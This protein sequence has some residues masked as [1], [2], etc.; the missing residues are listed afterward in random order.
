M[1]KD[2]RVDIPFYL[3]REGNSIKVGDYIVYGNNLGRCAQTAL[4]RVTRIVEKPK[5]AW[6]RTSEKVKSIQ[7]VSVQDKWG[8]AYPKKVWIQEVDRV[9]KYPVTL[10][11][12]KTQHMLRGVE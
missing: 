10:V 1:A 12:T 11:S 6:S 4:G 2:L 7:I 5:F 8:D 3:D 9:L